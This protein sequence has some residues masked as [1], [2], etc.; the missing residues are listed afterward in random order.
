[1]RIITGKGES[2]MKRTL[3]QDDVVFMF[4]SNDPLAYVKYGATV[5]A[6]GGP[7]SLKDTRRLSE[8]GIHYVSSI[9]CQTAGAHDLHANPDLRGATTL[10]FDG[11]PI[12]IPGL[13]HPAF[14]GTPYYYG[15][16]NHPTFRSYIGKKLCEAM[17]GNPSGILID[18]HLGTAEPA[19][20]SGGCFCEFCLRAFQEHLSTKTS[21]QLLANAGITSPKAFD[22]RKYV[23]DIK[24]PSGGGNPG[25]L[26]DLPLYQEFID[27]QLERAADNVAM[28]GRIAEEI[29]DSPVTLSVNA[30]LPRL[31]HIVAARHCTY[32]VGEV[33]HTAAEGIK[34]LINPVKAYRMAEAIDR[35]FAATASMTDWAFIKDH[36]A[37]QLACLWIA[38]AYACG[39]R[40]MVPNRVHCYSI[41]TGPGWYCGPSAAYAPLYAFVK[42]HSALLND[43]SPVGPLQ[44]PEGL[45]SGFETHEKRRR[46]ADV[47]E[48]GNP[49]PLQAGDNAWIFPRCRTDGLNVAHVINTAYNS[50][51]GKIR[52]QKDLTI[53]IP[54][55]LF[56]RNFDTATIYALDSEPVKA[57]VACAGGMM[58]VT[59]PELTIWSIIVFEYWQ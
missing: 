57:P 3:K 32:L 59:L 18:S 15:C 33:D 9:A 5:V 49:Q 47:L 43:F 48:K 50:K 35:P 45:P 36:N 37:E 31:E 38:L 8:M 11:K 46:F 40:F 39:Q 34:N 1:M 52:K 26:L 29:V 22:F 42:K 28:L 30:C 44:A 21:P 14:Q 55:S 25:R 4:S 7:N 13:E 2:A 53:T 23:H 16:T 51:T 10:C 56:K 58:S 19:L 27:F 20:R 17:V 54:E 41:E 6:W 24:I 12:A